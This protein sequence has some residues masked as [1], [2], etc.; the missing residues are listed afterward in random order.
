[1]KW[2]QFL[3]TSLRKLLAQPTLLFRDMKPSALVPC[4]VRFTGNATVVRENWCIQNL[5]CAGHPLAW[6]LGRLSCRL[7][8]AQ[9]SLSR[10]DRTFSGAYV[11]RH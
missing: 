10:T 3:R 8:L 4:C 11:Q 9:R 5:L 7:G 6:R 2:K 1:M